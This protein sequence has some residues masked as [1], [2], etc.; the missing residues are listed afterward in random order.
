M[1]IDES[2]V[3]RR[4][5][6]GGM[7]GGGAGALALGIGLPLVQYAG[8][9][10]EAPPPPRVEVPLA[11]GDLG[12]GR[13]KLIR[14]GSIP[15]LLFRTPEPR[16]ELK[17]FV[18]VCTHFDCTVGYRED[19]NCIFCACHEGYYDVDGKV[20]AGPPP[21]PLRPVYH[22]FHEG[23]LFVALEKENLEER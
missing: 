2:Y 11:D 3:A 14:Y 10:R 20:I 8:N 16:S 19:K 1:K 15:V 17:A 18:A 5:F 23:R 21:R 7:I 4:R 22:R 9:L 13:S 12:P 6:L